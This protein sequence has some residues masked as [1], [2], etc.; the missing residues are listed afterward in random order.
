MG[1]FERLGL[2]VLIVLTVVMVVI[3]GWGFGA[4]RS[5]FGPEP[6][7]PLAVAVGGPDGGSNATPQ[8]VDPLDRVAHSVGVAGPPA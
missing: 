1:I 5:D 4:P 8:P 7:T 3:T 6:G 2:L